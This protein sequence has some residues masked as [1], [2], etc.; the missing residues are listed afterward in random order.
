MTGMKRDSESNGE[1]TYTDR[2]RRGLASAYIEAM[3]ASASGEEVVV[4]SWWYEDPTHLAAAA[5]KNIADLFGLTD[6][7]KWSRGC[8]WHREELEAR[9]ECDG[10]WLMEWLNAVKGFDGTKTLVGN[11]CMMPVAESLNAYHW[12]VPKVNAGESVNRPHPV[13]DLV[14]WCA[15]MPAKRWIM[16]ARSTYPGSIHVDC[17]SLFDGLVGLV[18][19]EWL[20]PETAHG[21]VYYG[22]FKRAVLG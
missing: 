22:E 9:G 19:R 16:D 6:E 2:L 11:T 14:L 8:L 17:G 4:G 20:R 21:K 15:G 3:A 13:A 12:V 1:H 10:R 5:L 7:V 18:S